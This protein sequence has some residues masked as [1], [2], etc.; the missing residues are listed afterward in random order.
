MK[1]VKDD[2]PMSRDATPPP[3][4]WTQDPDSPQDEP[5]VT[6]PAEPEHQIIEEPGYGHGV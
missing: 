6:A 3:P 2:S 1:T 5:A 4:G